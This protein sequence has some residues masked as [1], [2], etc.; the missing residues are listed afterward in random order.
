KPLKGLF[1][2]ERPGESRHQPPENFKGERRHGPASGD[3]AAAAEPGDLARRHL[4][5]VV[6]LAGREAAGRVVVQRLDLQELAD[7]PLKLVEVRRG[8]DPA[9]L[10]QLANGG[11]GVDPGPA[12]DRRQVPLREREAGGVVQIQKKLRMNVEGGA[13]LAGRVRGG[14][15]LA[16]QGLVDGL[17]WPAQYGG[18]VRRGPAACLHLLLDKLSR[19]KNLSQGQVLVHIVLGLGQWY[20]S[21]P[22]RTKVTPASVSCR[23]RISLQGPFSLM[24]HSCLRLPFRRS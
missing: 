18:Q 11:L 4:R 23:W 16:G 22:V 14:G 15:L 17:G 12:G 2:G 8:R 10:D 5:V 21:M 20:C 19:R 9:P 6:A 24:D 7:L 13:Q 1:R 3:L